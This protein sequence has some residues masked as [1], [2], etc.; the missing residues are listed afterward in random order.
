M[1]SKT[2]IIGGGL[3]G[4]SL[5]YRLQMAGHDYHL[6]EA[7]DRLGGRI[8]SLTVDDI[9]FDLGPSWVWPG[10]E[11]IA[12]LL[13][14]LGLSTFEQWS[15][16]E[17]LFEQA[18]GEVIQN[19]GFISMA[20]SYRITGG[21]FALTE[22]LASRLD[23]ARL[24][25]GI[26][27]TT[28]TDQP[29]VMLS[30]GRDVT[31][32]RIALALPPRLA[33]QLPTTPPL[34]GKDHL[35]GIPTWMAAH[36]KFVAV[37]DSPFWRA[38]GLSGDAS[39]RRGPMVEIHDAS[40]KDGRLGALFGFVGIPAHARLS[41]EVELSAAAIAQLANL[42][43]PQAAAPIATRLEDW[44]TSPWTATAADAIPP[45]GHPAYVMPKTFQH[46]WDGKL[47]FCTTEMAPDNGGLIEGALGA[48]EVAA[49]KILHT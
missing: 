26:A 40:P 10:Q 49:E 15:T 45:A 42:F 43:G 32:D 14:E 16:G 31:G 6:I 1:H 46:I 39:S 20:G 23:P 35:S 29:S 21:T 41:N 19:A 36:A 5:A 48:A 22:A 4:L 2:L 7:R 25:R 28:I 30:D 8:K 33:A 12:T 38:A 37:Y 24:T 47:I 34:S 44:S 17:Q 11:R 27:A 18:S 13:P 9:A 3:S